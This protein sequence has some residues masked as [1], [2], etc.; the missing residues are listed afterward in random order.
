MSDDDRFD[1][2]SV[3]RRRFFQPSAATGAALAVPGNA[4]AAAEDD[5]FTGGRTNRVEL[6]VETIEGDVSSNTPVTVT[7]EIPDGWT[8]DTDSGDAEGDGVIEG[9]ATVS[10]GTVTPGDVE[11]GSVTREYFAEAPEGADETG[12]DTF[13]PATA[14]IGDEKVSDQVAGTD[15]NTVVGPSTEV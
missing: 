5:A 13:G 10:L 4:T 2:I 1:D 8:V 12:R 9:P 3:S 6:T 11:E 15:T 7:D 14:T